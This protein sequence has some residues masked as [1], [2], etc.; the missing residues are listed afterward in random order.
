MIPRGERSIRNIPVSPGHHHRRPQREAEPPEEQ[1]TFE[2]EE[3]PRRRKKGRGFGARFWIAA[4]IV[5]ALSFVG[6]MLLSSLFAGATVEVHPLVQEVELP[7]TLTASAGAGSGGLRFETMTIRRAATTTV[8]AS[9]TTQV[10]RQASGVITIFNTYSTAN[11]LLIANTRFEAQDGKIYRIRESA[12]VP[13]RSASG[14]PGTVS[15]TVYADSPGADYNKEGTVRFTI[16]GFRGDPR[17][18]GFYAEASGGISGGYVGPEPAVVPAELARAEAALRSEVET[19]VRTAAAAELP[20]GYVPVPGTLAINYS[21]IYRT[22]AG[23]DAQLSQTA[24]ATAA[25]IRTADLAAAIAEESLPETYRGE[26][27]T[28]ADPLALSLSVATTSPAEGP[29]DLRLAGRAVLVWQF[30]PTLFKQELLGKKRSE[31]E[32]VRQTFAPAIVRA[33]ATIRPFWQGSFPQDPEDISIETV[34]GE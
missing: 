19:A 16:P 13:G 30:D 15:V 28:L 22:L 17:Y 34:L 2:H 6:A 31:L 4:G 10:S 25:I 3:R 26:A 18:E 32:V 9:G 29:L 33:D 27:V 14:E 24:V 1:E 5:A 20:Q 8:E 23:D 12:T 11:Q 21:N 7:E